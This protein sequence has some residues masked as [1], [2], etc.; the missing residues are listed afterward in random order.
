MEK[1]IFL[2]I[3]IKGNLLEKKPQFAWKMLPKDAAA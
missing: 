1:Q 3:Q 2:L